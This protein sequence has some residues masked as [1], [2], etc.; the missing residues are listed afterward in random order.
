MRP[1][2]HPSGASHSWEAA[3]PLRRADSLETLP[4]VPL[5][6]PSPPLE[7]MVVYDEHFDSGVGVDAGT[8]GS[9]S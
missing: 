6:R 1:G 8:A 2:D 9:Q 7:D 3:N 4:E 5:G